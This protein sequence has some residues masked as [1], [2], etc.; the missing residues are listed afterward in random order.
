MFSDQV[1]LHLCG[2]HDSR[3]YAKTLTL[4]NLYGLVSRIDQGQDITQTTLVKEFDLQKIGV[5]TVSKGK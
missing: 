4:N 2:I 3:E 1:S 5:D